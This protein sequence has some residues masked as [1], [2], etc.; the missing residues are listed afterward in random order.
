MEMKELQKRQAW[1]L[2]TKI[3]YSKE[4]IKEW[5]EYW[6]GKVYVSFSGGKDSTVLLDLVRSIYP[7]VEAAFINTGLEYP[8]INKFVKTIDNVTW[9]RPKMPF[10]KVIE[11]YGYPVISKENSQKIDEIRN[12]NS[13]KLRNKRLHGDD[14]GNGKLPKKWQFMIEAPFSISHKCCHALK[15][16]PVKKYEKQT[17]NKPFVGTMVIDSSLRKINYLQHGCNNFI[18]KRGMSLPLSF[19]KETD[20]WNYIK[21]KNLAYSSIYDMGYPNTGCMFCM[22]GVHLEKNINRFQRMKITHPKQYDYCINKLGCG[23]VLD[24]INVKY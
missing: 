2:E 18:A 14:K 9:L 16:N 11:K 13:A 10:H 12:T 1:E 6:E 17:G 15:K 5:Y 22:F 24:F 3:E 4:K 20:I 21:T 23:K 7:D 8:E 19:W